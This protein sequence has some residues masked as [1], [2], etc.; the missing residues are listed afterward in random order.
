M[1]ILTGRKAVGLCVTFFPQVL[2]VQ[3]EEL[4]PE[5]DIEWELMQNVS[6]SY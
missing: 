2:P 4:I 1:S 5:V 3:S 6:I